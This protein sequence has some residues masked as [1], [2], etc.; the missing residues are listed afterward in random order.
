MSVNLNMR[1]RFNAYILTRPRTRKV[2]GWFLIVF[3]SLGII[4]P[5]VP[6]WI[7]IFVGLEVLGLQLVFRNKLKSFF[8]RDAATVT[9]DN[10]S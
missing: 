2:V 10:Q 1:Q 4:L 3:G 6:G 7:A 5:L 8:L 9:Q